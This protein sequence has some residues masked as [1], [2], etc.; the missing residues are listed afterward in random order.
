MAL[1]LYFSVGYENSSNTAARTS[2]S[3]LHKED[4]RPKA[5]QNHKSSSGGNCDVNHINKL[6]AAATKAELKAVKIA[7]IHVMPQGGCTSDLS[8][9]TLTLF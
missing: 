7:L 3:D 2:T 8:F 5:A 4:S 1:T 6:R 9:E